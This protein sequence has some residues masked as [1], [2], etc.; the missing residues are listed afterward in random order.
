MYMSSIATGVHTMVHLHNNRIWSTLHEA[1]LTHDALLE[2]CDKHLVYLGFGIFLQLIKR[3]PIVLGTL[4]SKDP[5]TQQDL[6]TQARQH[7]KLTP[8]PWVVV[9]V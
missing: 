5:D 4:S 3:E 2:Q 9:M 1:P 7:A 6:L 8:N